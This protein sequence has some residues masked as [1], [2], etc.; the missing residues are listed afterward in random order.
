ME[1]LKEESVPKVSIIVPHYKGRRLI[2]ECLS[3]LQKLNYP[4]EQLEIKIVDN[5]SSDGSLR[6]VG[7][8]FPRVS[9]LKNKENNYCKAN[10]IGF[11]HSTG[12]Y[13]GFLNNDTVADKNWLMG[14]VKV[15]EQDKKIGCAGGKILL[16]DG[17]IQSA[18]HVEFPGH[19]WGDR[20]FREPDLGQYNIPEEIESLSGSALLFRR[21]CLK[22]VG[23]FDEDFVM[24]LEDIDIFFRCRKQGWKICYVPESIVYH[25]LHGTADEKQVRFY[26]ERNRLLL[27]AKHFPDE[28][29]KALEGGKHLLS[30]EELFRVLPDMFLKLLKE[31]G[32]KVNDKQIRTFFTGL[33]HLYNFAK[34]KSIQELT[35]LVQEAKEK[36]EKAQADKEAAVQEKTGFENTVLK[37]ERRL[38]ETKNSYSALMEDSGARL[39]SI[40]LKLGEDL[41]KKYALAEELK[42]EVSGKNAMVEKLVGEKTS[43]ELALVQKGNEAVEKHSEIKSL[44]AS[45]IQLQNQL[46]LVRQELNHRLEILHEM[47]KQR[48][49]LLNETN[50]RGEVIRQLEEGTR[51]FDLERGQLQGQL[52][53]ERIQLQNQ[54]D[55][56]RQ[57]LNHRLEILHEMEKQR[58]GLQSETNNKGEV[59]RQLEERTRNFEIE[60]AQLSEKIN[61]IQLELNK[62][63]DIFKD[64]QVQRDSLLV[65]VK[66]LNENFNQQ[67]ELAKKQENEALKVTLERE[68]EKEE[69]GKELKSGSDK[70]QRLAEEVEVAGKL[71]AELEL[72]I[73]D[74]GRIIQ[75]QESL[76]AQ[77]KQGVLEKE[78]LLREVEVKS[79][80]MASQIDTLVQS[81][82][83]YEG[84]V[85]L[86]KLQIV[87]KDNFIKRLLNS[88]THR[89]LVGPLWRLSDFIKWSF[90]IKPEAVKTLLVIK[91]FYVS[92]EQTRQALTHLRNQFGASDITLVANIFHEEFLRLQDCPEANKKILFS[93]TQHKLTMFRFLRL[94]FWMNLNYFDRAVI[95]IGPPIYQG[96]RKGKLLLLFSG[97]K[98]INTYFTGTH[99]TAPLYSLGLLK[100]LV[101]PFEYV[102]SVVSFA[103][104]TALFFVGVVIPLKMRKMFHR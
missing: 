68:Q 39:E 12:Q 93:P 100:S 23:E 85:E 22:D 60:R 32:E 64:M 62:Q 80:S 81:A 73:N 44:S 2:I 101:L 20:G 55:L 29:G 24:Y 56:V 58:D 52:K 28:L 103:G 102:W 16:P 21:D 13:I 42:K 35:Y 6:G 57:E 53:V 65:Q 17:R 92:V 3:S 71:K 14:L 88:R 4:K 86:Q 8:E 104:V 63:L 49:G 5:C 15:M 91:P 74:A 76:I 25:K 7:R 78:I 94:F 89:Y 50:S 45:L 43:L 61:V 66:N 40:I 37:L 9:I 75:E 41:E 70:L 11:E 26:I 98:S 30:Q 47:E 84:T 82:A 90:G 48:D 99:K 36:W 46:D 33:H 1:F 31:H 59:I 77:L 19:Y 96:Y 87:E 69:F 54:L 79:R 27:I 51:Q 95:L 72:R 10:N 97:A 34:D 18:G 38:V 67:Y 83:Q